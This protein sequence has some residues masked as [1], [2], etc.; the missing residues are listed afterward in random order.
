[1]SSILL[2]NQIKTI[3]SLSDINIFAKPNETA[4]FKNI[5]NCV[6]TNIYS[7]LETSGS[8]SSNL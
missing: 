7:F 1:M 3:F 5:N 6:N 8:Q 4:Q 2:E